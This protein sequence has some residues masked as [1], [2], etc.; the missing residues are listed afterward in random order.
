MGSTAE[1]TALPLASLLYNAGLSGG[2]LAL[3]LALRVL[4]QA[5]ADISPSSEDRG[6]V[7]GGSRDVS[8]LKFFVIF[9]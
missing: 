7:W 5:Q 2:G 6:F 1:R 4:C 8:L 3:A 9:F